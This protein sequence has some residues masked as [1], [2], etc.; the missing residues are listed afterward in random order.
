VEDEED[1]IAKGLHWGESIQ[2]PTSKESRGEDVIRKHEKGEAGLSLTDKGA[3]ST[4]KKIVQASIQR[5]MNM[6]KFDD[7]L[8]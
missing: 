4:T 3:A 5:R 1:S 8:K 7:A 2:A 6:V